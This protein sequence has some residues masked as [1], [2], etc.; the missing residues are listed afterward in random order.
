MGLFQFTRLA[1]AASIF[2]GAAWIVAALAAPAMAQVRINFSLD[3]KLEGPAAFFLLPQDRGYFKDE[4][5]DVTIDEGNSA[6]EPITRVASGSYEMG[7]A[8]INALIKYR[9]QNPSAPIKAV[10]MVYNKPPYAIVGRKSRGIGEPRSLEGKK[11]G[12]PPT[13][14]TFAVWPLFAKL[15][16]ID[17][18]KVSIEKIGI[19]VRVPMLAAGQLDA[20]LGYAFRVYVDIKDRGVPVDDVVLLQ[21]ANYGMKLY[22]SAVV[23]NTKFAGEKPEA[24]KAFLHATVKGLRE[25]IRSPAGAV[26]LGAQARGCGQE[27]G[28]A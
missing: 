27:R 18:S 20:T 13:G 7:F 21:M 10:F 4:G 2:M 9:D 24:V 15:N 22:G 8:D 19:P 11:L 6:I 5:L 23:V 28:R 12:A 26:E 17:L 14:S 25:T 16:E 3:E 1:R